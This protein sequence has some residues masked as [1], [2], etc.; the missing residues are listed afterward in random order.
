MMFDNLIFKQNCKF[1]INLNN[2]NLE[3]V[4]YKGDSIKFS[5]DGQK[6][7]AKV[8]KIVDNVCELCII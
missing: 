6:Y 1:Y 8:I 7:F 2:S 4:L 3:V 5:H